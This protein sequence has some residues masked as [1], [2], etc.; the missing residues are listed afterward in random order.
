M[1]T[2]IVI[3]GLLVLLYGCGI[4]V[5]EDN[6]SIIDDTGITIEQEIDNDQVTKSE[7]EQEIIQEIKPEIEEEII[8]EVKTEIEQEI[9]QEVKTKLEEETNEEIESNLSIDFNEIRE[10]EL[11]NIPSYSSKPYVIINNNIPFFNV[12]ELTTNSYEKYDDL[13]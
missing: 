8:Q 10:N 3:L 6:E 5:H 1:K 7:I 4:T 12:D 11:E 9:D 13:D 2:F